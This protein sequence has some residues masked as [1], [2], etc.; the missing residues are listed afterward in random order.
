MNETENKTTTKSNSAKVIAGLVVLV[1]L[2]CGVWYFM[3]NR[4][5]V[6]T[7]EANTQNVMPDF[8][9]SGSG[10]VVWNTGATQQVS[11]PSL[12]TTQDYAAPTGLNRSAEV[13]TS[14]TNT[15]NV[16]PDFN[17]SGSNGVAWNAGATQQAAQPSIGKAQ[18]QTAPVSPTLAAPQKTS[19]L[20]YFDST[21]LK[22]GQM[23]KIEEFI[24]KIPSGYQ[25]EILV[26]GY[27]CDIGEDRY[28][29]D[30]SLKR[31][32]AIANLLREKGY[33][34]T[35]IV[36]YGESAYPAQQGPARYQYRRVDISVN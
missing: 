9:S 22:E 17:S 2:L 31:A 30:L 15:Q 28:N 19:V 11:Q 26:E 6:N 23:V 24:K 16:M 5:Q 33:Q 10:G 4:N 1:A 27:T 18:D 36:P 29:E 20:F 32:N 14:E 13:D 35:K 12:S 7:H 3:H 21:K 25:G 8:N 34:N